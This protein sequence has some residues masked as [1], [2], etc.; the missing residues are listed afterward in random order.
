M[1]DEFRFQIVN[2]H[3]QIPATTEGASNP[4]S[5][6]KFTGTLTLVISMGDSVEVPVPGLEGLAW[7]HI[8]SPTKLSIEMGE[9]AQYVMSQPELQQD[10]T[11]RALALYPIEDGDYPGVDR[12]AA[13]RA[14]Y[15][16][17][18]EEHGR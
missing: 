10:H 3:G 11:A 14:A 15:L 2:L 8:P 9:D 5:E 12:N 16:R 13:A 1:T 17:G 4:F 18:R 6:I 7:W